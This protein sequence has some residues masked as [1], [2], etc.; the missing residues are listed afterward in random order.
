MAGP[1]LNDKEVWLAQDH[2][3]KYTTALDIVPILPRWC[4]RGNCA[5]VI[6]DVL[7]LQRG[8]LGEYV[9]GLGSCRARRRT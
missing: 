6:C 5:R 9:H 4:R 7:Q 3:N 2:L 8:L 1:M